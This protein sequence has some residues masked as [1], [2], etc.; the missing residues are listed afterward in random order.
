MTPIRVLHCPEL[1]G[2][3]AQQLARAERAL[4]LESVAVAFEQTVFA[5]DTDEVLF[6]PSDR[7]LRRELEALRA[8]APRAARLRRRP[9]QLRPDD[10]AGSARRAAADVAQPRL[11]PRTRASSSSATCRCSSARG[12]RSS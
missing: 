10:D 4:G 12:R 8:A 7:L 2:G 1:V 5:Y 3:N 9:L 6:A 11:S